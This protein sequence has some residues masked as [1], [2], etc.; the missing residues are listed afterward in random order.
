MAETG[1]HFEVIYYLVKPARLVSSH[2]PDHYV[3]CDMF[4]YWEEGNPK[5][6]K[7]PDVMVIKGVELRPPR[8]NFKIWEEGATSA[9]IFEITSPSTATED[10][11]GKLQIYEQIGVKEYFLFD[12]LYEYLAGPLMGYRL[13]GDKYEPLMPSANGCLVSNELQL[14][15]A[16]RAIN[17]FYSTSARANGYPRRRKCDSSA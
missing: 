13:I 2:R 7:A 1:I 15:C 9:V 10:A 4:L 6:R 5:A 11:T 14:Q 12:P 16:R 8:P 17:S 3:A